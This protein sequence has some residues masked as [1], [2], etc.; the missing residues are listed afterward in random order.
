NVYT[1]CCKIT[2]CTDKVGKTHRPED[3]DFKDPI[4]KCNN[5]KCLKNGQIQCTDKQ[6]CKQCKVPNMKALQPRGYTY[7][8][9]DGCDECECI[10]SPVTNCKGPCELEGAKVTE[11]SGDSPCTE[12]YGLS[13]KIKH[14]INTN[15]DDT[16]KTCRI[17]KTETKECNPLLMPKTGIRK[18]EAAPL[19]IGGKKVSPARNYRWMAR[20]SHIESPHGLLCGG[21]VISRLHVLTAAHCICSYCEGCVVKDNQLV[22]FFKGCGILVTVGDHS[23]STTNEDVEQVRKS[24]VMQ[25]HRNY[26]STSFD[27]DIAILTLEHPLIFNDD[28]QPVLLPKIPPGILKLSK[29]YCT[30][31]GWGLTGPGG[32][33][34]E[35]QEAGLL[36]DEECSRAS[37]VTTENMICANIERSGADSCYGDSGGGLSCRLFGPKY[38]WAIFGIVSTG[39]RRCGANGGGA[40]TKVQNYVDWIEKHISTD[41]SWGEWSTF[42][43]CSQ[44]GQRSRS[45]VCTDP[46]PISH[47]SCTALNGEKMNIEV[48]TENC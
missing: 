38:P 47:G 13:V 9:N 45:R 22:P 18:T 16:T 35:L 27:N 15:L 39:S 23:I 11:W 48:D 33:S 28:V 46:L 8:I 37:I 43:P 19:V 17:T 34:D 32:I 7:T 10:S 36:L 42:T 25:I 12:E 14:C 41:G 40:Y 2:Q 3:G 5:C 31:V 21:S 30:V 20:L 29:R 26:N 1:M 6:A 24:F 44:L 4:D